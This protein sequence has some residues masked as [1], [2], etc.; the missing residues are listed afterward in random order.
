MET[1]ELRKLMK[2]RPP[3]LV[4]FL[5][6]IGFFLMFMYMSKNMDS[7]AISDIN[8]NLSDSFDLKTVSIGITSDKNVKVNR[9]YDTNN[10][11]VYS[12]DITNNNGSYYLKDKKVEDKGLIYILSNSYP[13]KDFKDKNGN[14]INVDFQTWIS[15]V[16][17]WLYLN[18][19]NSNIDSSLLENI[20]T[21][22]K[23]SFDNNNFISNSIYEEYIKNLV[24]NALVIKDNDQKINVFV[25]D[26]VYITKNKKYYQS[27]VITVNSTDPENFKGYYVKINNAPNGSFIVDEEG[28]KIKTDTMLKVTDKF[29]LRVPKSKV[30][31]NNTSIKLDVV[32][33]YDELEAYFYKSDGYSNLISSR[34]FDKNIEASL[35]INF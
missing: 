32:G 19:V 21:S 33:V 15:Q 3:L 22:K 16:A 12:L 18:E 13:N 31:V 4:S 17:I 28:N 30:N 6:L 8:S 35:Y 11:Q 1:K 24:N 34:K 5:I 27:S 14:S 26:D 10:N 23:L 9:M 2:Y 29:Y 20:K 7:Y 25:D